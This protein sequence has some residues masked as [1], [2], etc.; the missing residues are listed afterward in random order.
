MAMN[1]DWI[2]GG[3]WLLTLALLCLGLG[4]VVAGQLA[5][6]TG[7]EPPAVTA[8]PAPAPAGPRATVEFAPPPL[9]QFAE[10]VERPLFSESR[11]PPETSGEPSGPP[12]PFEGALV[13]TLIIQGE[14]IALLK[15]AGEP[16][17]TRVTKGQTIRGWLVVEIHPDRVVLQGERT[18]EIRL[19]EDTE[20]G[21]PTATGAPPGQPDAQRPRRP[22]P[23]PGAQPPGQ[24]QRR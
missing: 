5:M 15:I 12:K 7:F 1:L 6:S 24:P 16:E 21:R 17:V 11:R 23:Q 22:T 19:Q 9:S 14:T 13:G 3:R 10:T 20:I 4:A 18:A 8:S 2:G